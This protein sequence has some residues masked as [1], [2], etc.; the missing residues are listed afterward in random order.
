MERVYNI[1]LEKYCPWSENI[2]LKTFITKSPFNVERI[3][4]NEE[5][6]LRVKNEKMSMDFFFENEEALN[7]GFGYICEVL[8]N[9][10]YNENDN[11]TITLPIM[12][13]S[14][15]NI[16]FLD[17]LQKERKELWENCD[18]HPTENGCK[19][20]TQN[21]KFEPIINPIKN[22]KF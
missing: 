19:K 12:W 10:D 9:F 8:S 6:G 7:S 1:L 22:I 3:F 21:E 4:E 2:P 15:D 11:Y 20:C 13:D 17:E 5:Y 16:H 14:S 18:C